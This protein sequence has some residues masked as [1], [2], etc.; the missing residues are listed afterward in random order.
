MPS[1]LH[2]IEAL[3]ASSD[4]TAAIVALAAGTAYCFVGYRLIRFF[5]GLTG[6]IL[7]GA[8]AMVLTSAALPDQPLFILAAGL[9]GGVAG[10]LALFFLYKSGVFLLGLTGVGLIARGLLAPVAEP[11]A[12]WAVVAAAIAGGLIAL[13]LERPL[14]VIATAAIGSFIVIYAFSY[15]VAGPEVLA[16]LRQFG[17][18]GSRNLV[19]MLCWLVLAVVGAGTQ[20]VAFRPKGAR[21]VRVR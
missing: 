18:Y 19:L 11:W 5:I 10:A 20:L 16:D 21:R 13:M 3:L 2:E 6:F 17:R 8:A 14:L 1:F 15:L 9:V 7:A 12:P 4:Q